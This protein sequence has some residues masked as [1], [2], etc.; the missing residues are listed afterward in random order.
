LNKYASFRE[1]KIKYT[2]T[3]KGRVV[4]FLHGFL[5]DKSMW[6][7]YPTHL[8]ARIRSICIDLPGHGNSDNFGYVHSMELMAESVRAVLK[9]EGIRKVI[10][11]G[12]SLGGY[13]ALAFA[14]LYPDM[15]KGL[16][17][18]FSSAAADTLEKK[19]NRNR[20]I[21]LVEKNKTSFVRASIPLL[22][23]EH[24]RTKHL[25]RISSLV[26]NANKMG[27]QSIIAALG[28]MRD[29]SDRE[30]VLKFAPFPITFVSGDLD[31]VLPIK[32][33]EKQSQ[34]PRNSSITILKNTGHMGYIENKKET[35][36]AV[37]RFIDTIYPH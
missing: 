17:M 4:V 15:M 18:Y 36:L 34:L 11:V 7:Y 14:E 26:G 20:A 12:H 6:R 21:K 16:I 27:V 35:F 31:P 10:L 33:L 22:F 9:Q 30:I 29:R 23:A 3:G 19:K 24:N 37:K 25:K 5:E 1:G 28:G 13:V 32:M 8:P 2:D